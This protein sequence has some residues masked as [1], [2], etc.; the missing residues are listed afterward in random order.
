MTWKGLKMNKVELQGKIIRIFEGRNR[1]IV[2]MFVDGY[3]KNYPQIVCNGEMRNKIKEYGVGDF[4]HVDGTIKVRT[5]TNED[6]TRYYN[7]YIKALDIEPALSDLEKNF[8]LDVKGT[9][10]YINKVFISGRNIFTIGNNNVSSIVVNT[11]DDRFNVQLTAFRD[12]NGFETEYPK[13]VTV[14]IRGE[15]QTTRK[16][17][18]DGT[19]FYENFIVK[20]IVKSEEELEPE[21]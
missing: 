16:E 7:Q 9:A 21:A 6:G 10:E 12:I 13:D 18:E 20:D 14:F 1:T 2:T 17:A 19:H 8:G 4:I 3:G 11:P 5:L 15:V